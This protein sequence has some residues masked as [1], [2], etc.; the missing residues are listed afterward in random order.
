MVTSC[1]QAKMIIMF[2]MFAIFIMYPELEEEEDIV[3]V[4]KGLTV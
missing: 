3:I 4:F 2:W 1:Q